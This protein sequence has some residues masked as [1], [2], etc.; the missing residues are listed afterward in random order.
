MPR[1][2]PLHTHR[3]TSPSFDR[4]KL[5]RA[6]LVDA[7]LSN[8]ERK[9]IVVAAPAG[10]GKTTLLAD[11]GAHADIPTCWI[12][13]TS[14]DR[15]TVRL[16]EAICATIGQRFRRFAA[17]TKRSLAGQTAPA[18]I[19][20]G[21]ADSVR[22]SIREPFALLIDDGHLL[23]ASQ[24]ALDLLDVLI[25]ELPEEMTVIVAGREVLE[26][27]L[28]R[29][30]ANGDL[31][32]FG[33]HDLAFTADELMDLTRLQSGDELG[34]ERAEALIHSTRGWITGLLLTGSVSAAHVR[35][36]TDG[37]QPMVYDYLASVV[38]A[39]QTDD[40]R[41]FMLDAA[42]LPVMTAEACDT[43]LRRDDSSERLPGLVRK[44]LFVAVSEDQVATYEFHPL[45]RQFLLDTAEREDRQ[46]LMRLRLRAAAYLARQGRIEE[47]VETYLEAGARMRAVALMQSH[48]LAMEW[49]GHYQTL[50]QWMAW[51]DEFD[52]KV[53][54]VYLRL[55]WL[56][57][58]QAKE[59]EAVRLASKG[60]SLL[61]ND[62]PIELWCLAE[63]TL[64]ALAIQ[65]GD[66]DSINLILDG[67][68]ER[69]PKDRFTWIEASIHESRAAAIT[70]AGA[71]A[72]LAEVELR[73]AI[74]IY[75][76]EG[77]EYREA[78]ALTT[79]FN[80]LGRQGRSLEGEP[81]IRKALGLLSTKYPGSA[82][83]LDAANNYAVGLHARGEVEE[84][85]RLLQQGLRQ[86]RRSGN[87]RAE[88]VILLSQADL[89]ND[90]G[91]PIQAA[92]LYDQG[93]LRSSQAKALWLVRYGCLLACSLHR[94]QGRLET[95]AAWLHRAIAVESG[96]TLWSDLQVE[97]AA[98]LSA[99]DP[100]QAILRLQPVLAETEW[101]LTTAERARAMYQLLRCRW[102]AGELEQARAEAFSLLGWIT[103][104]GS[105]Q[106]IAAELL[107]D[108]ALVRFLESDLGTDSAWNQLLSR[109]HLLQSLARRFGSPPVESAPPDR[110]VVRTL[111]RSDLALGGQVLA[112]LKPLA[113]EV[114]FFLV[115]QRRVERDVLLEQFWPEHMP[116]RQAAN[117]HMAI[118]GL[119][120]E[121]GKDAIALDG[122]AYQLAP[123]V[124][125]DYDADSFEHV[126]GLAQRLAP[127]D[128]RRLFA[129]TEAVNT[130]GGAFLPSLSSS[131]VQDRRRALES[132]Y[133]DLL[134]L[135]AD[136]ALVSAQPE[137]AARFL[138]M[139]LDIDPFRDD[140]HL[141]YLEA[142]GELGRQS[143]IVSHYRGYVRL[144]ADELGL[145]PPE[146][147]RSLYQRLIS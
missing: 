59:D 41:R 18:G 57:T 65:R 147:I 3:I 97:T 44:G 21:I 115:D 132:R 6:R 38:L 136:E 122:S 28:A 112:E 55:A 45:F 123:S 107:A 47:A 2:D 70:H 142:L 90:L 71:D 134:A 145:D 15:D 101:K 84:A 129:L 43:V 108:P 69:K 139:A 143:E 109:V 33:P 60:R 73:Q 100:G 58:E 62:Q 52:L 77:D 79:L 4:T 85:M 83:H 72:H 12:R 48:A 104:T 105:A 29:L 130:Y 117:L 19:A 67:I 138:R 116:G 95:A 94:K 37:G 56:A 46:R 126:A 51:A 92:E 78:R 32:G 125:L 124:K 93:I 24:P 76:S 7:I 50:E 120:R 22:D 13:L 34:A 64:C 49:R 111:G 8:I 114:L 27:S 87:V 113:R 118:Y 99:D 89:F 86:A 23:N 102:L 25:A 106:P 96:R 36:F 30:M 81:Y 5:H 61:E 11:F 14:A 80:S 133:L 131:W 82:E 39:Q 119:R 42:C 54:E 74:E 66:V 128:P 10:Y 16:G 91:L 110:L 135:A 98:L 17:I 40:L 63:L 137:A 20:R 144:L 75:R 26:V 53:P 88:G 35:A 140:V 127:G 146:P 31:A 1:P 9:L 103:A 121:L 68:V 141:R